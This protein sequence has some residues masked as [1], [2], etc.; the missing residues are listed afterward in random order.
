MPFTTRPITRLIP[1]A[2][3]NPKAKQEVP[4]MG[5]ILKV[6]NLGKSFPGVKALASVDFDLI[7]GEIHGL[8]GENGAGKSTLIKVI[9]GYYKKDSGTIQYDGEDIDFGSP[10]D[11]VKKG[12]STVYQEINLIPL[13]SVAENIFLG[14]QPTHKGGRIDWKVLHEK[15]GLALAR[16]DLQ[17]DVTRPLSSFSVAIQQLVSIARA[18]DIS[19]RIL[20]LDEPTSSLDAAEVDRLFRVLR[21]LRG[22]G[23]GI[24]FITHFLDQVFE[25]T[26][27][28]SVLRNGRK[29]GV[30]ETAKLSRIELIS[31]MLG[32]EFEDLD[33]SQW[34]KG[35][36]KTGEEY[37]SLNK[38]S[39]QGFI[40]EFDLTIR[41][42]EVLGLAGLLGSGRT[43][44]AKLLYGIEKPETGEI[45]VQGRKVSLNGPRNAIDAGMG[46]C[47]EDRKEVGIFP[48]LSVR[49][50]II[51]AL[52]AKR[53]LFHYLNLK[54][55]NEI[56]RKLIKVLNIA[57]PGMGQ[58]V[59]NLSGGNQQKVILARWLAADPQLLI[60]DEPTRGIDI[61]SKVEIQK[62]IIELREKGMA[63]VFISSE[64]DEVVRCSTR[65]AVLRDRKIVRELLD[66]EINEKAI[67][68]TI[69]GNG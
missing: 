7:E 12:I 38:V 25:I 57:T 4:R 62:L 55:R 31:C 69:A 8:M 34:R 63:I 53:G 15:A 47:P 11:A 5:E 67:M 65:I 2:V 58:Q 52:Q 64:L 29:V 33:S 44:I 54:T 13:L 22:R 9:T 1:P 30:Y 51:L 36:E 43:E 61:G 17:I 40:K 42:G 60:L 16:L 3:S 45:L 37:L 46:F 23:M 50:N 19:A 35:A 6:A 27:R 24:I 21:R 68:Q 49:D 41:K 56:T 59:K 39:K 20:I 18:L 14:R 26:D 32:K 28:V 48:E 66:A 10:N